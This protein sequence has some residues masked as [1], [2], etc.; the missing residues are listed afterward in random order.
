MATSAARSPVVSSVWARPTFPNTTM[1]MLGR[2]QC[3]AI[4]PET[5]LNAL[6]HVGPPWFLRLGGLCAQP[7]EQEEVGKAVE[8]GVCE[9]VG[10]H[11]I[12][13]VDIVAAHQRASPAPLKFHTEAA[14]PKHIARWNHNVGPEAVR[15]M[16]PLLDGTWR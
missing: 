14:A 12:E 3:G 15:S 2:C 1:T 11:A 10:V 13:V 6:N 9:L 4:S 5:E 16:V 8:G 7:H